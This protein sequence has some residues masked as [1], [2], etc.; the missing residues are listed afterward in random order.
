MSCIKCDGIMRSEDWGDWVCE[1]CG[2]TKPYICENCGADA[3]YLNKFY[4]EDEE[5]GS[6]YEGIPF[7]ECTKCLN[8]WEL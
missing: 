8:Y 5:E 3:S 6:S 2:A 4:F 7:G 1:K